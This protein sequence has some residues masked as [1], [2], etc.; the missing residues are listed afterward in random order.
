MLGSDCLPKTSLG[1]EDRTCDRTRYIWN[2]ERNI[3]SLGV[4]ND[5]NE[6]A[7]LPKTIYIWASYLFSEFQLLKCDLPLP[8]LR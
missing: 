2:P 7:A 8:L 6:N 3:A 5:S 1:H 4:R